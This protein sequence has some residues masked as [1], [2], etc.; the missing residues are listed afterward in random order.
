MNQVIRQE[1]KKYL[2]ELI[3]KWQIRE[4][5]SRRC[6]ITIIQNVDNPFEFTHRILNYYYR[7]PTP[8]THTNKFSNERTLTTPLYVPFR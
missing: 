6:V 1:V 3:K 2:A 4:L 7:L 5:I 8:E